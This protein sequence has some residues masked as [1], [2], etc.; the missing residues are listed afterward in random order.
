MLCTPNT[1]FT[2]MKFG[3]ME[4]FALFFYK[5]FS[6]SEC[7]PNLIRQQGHVLKKSGVTEMTL[8]SKEWLLIFNFIISLWSL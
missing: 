4:S 1:N 8:P 5:W 6:A 2:V 3:L 7:I